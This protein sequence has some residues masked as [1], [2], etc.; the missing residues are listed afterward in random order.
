MVEAKTLVNDI[1]LT[2]LT[3]ILEGHL[4]RLEVIEC[5]LMA[6]VPEIAKRRGSLLAGMI[7]ATQTAALLLDQVEGL[8]KG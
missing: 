1:D 6:P 3:N 4:S 8:G 5:A 7:E 2:D